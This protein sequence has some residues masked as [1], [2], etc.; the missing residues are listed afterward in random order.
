MG[1]ID[2]IKERFY[3]KSLPAK[4]ARNKGRVPRNIEEAKTIGIL[5][6]A[7]DIDYRKKTLAYADKLR[8][9]GKKVST[10]GFIATADKEAT[11]SFDFFTLRQIDWA[12]RPNGDA[13]THWLNLDLEVLICL[14]PQ[15]SKF[16][17]Y[18]ALH[19]RAGL[20]IGPVA[21]NPSC[22]DL[23]LD[24]PAKSTPQQIIQQYEQVLAKTVPQ[25]V[26]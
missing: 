20:K 24:M 8:K 3:L 6:D 18:L 7:T 9:Q 22:Y 19:T 12:Q 16:T 25:K 10:L 23:M 5:F 26:A 1:I 15:S 2:R 14:F 4:I 17:E 13:I 11:F 21:T